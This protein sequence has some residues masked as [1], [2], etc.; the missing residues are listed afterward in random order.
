MGVSRASSPRSR[1]QTYPRQPRKGEGERGEP[2]RGGPGAKPRAMLNRLARR[3]RGRGKRLYMQVGPLATARFRNCLYQRRR[4]C[5]KNT[6]SG[7][8]RIAEGRIARAPSSQPS[9]VEGLRRRGGER[10]VRMRTGKGLKSASR[11]AISKIALFS[12]QMRQT[13]VLLGLT[14][15][16]RPA[17]LSTNISPRYA[18]KRGRRVK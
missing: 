4:V 5:I 13:A 7:D 6:V 18:D 1:R 9:P 17:I 15:L 8:E 2:K 12:V 16:I 10:G 3:T 11:A 14:A